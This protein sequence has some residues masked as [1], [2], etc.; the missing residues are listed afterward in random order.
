MIAVCGEALVDLVPDGP[1]SYAALPGG[2]PANCAVALSRLGVPTLLLARLSRDASGRLLRAHLQANGVDLSRAIDADEPSSLAVVS[3]AEDGSA[4]YRFLLEGT[5]DWQWTDDE[6]PALPPAVVAVHSGSL[7]LGRSRPLERFVARCR[8]TSTISIDPNLRAAFLDGATADLDRWLEVADVVKVSTE[9]IA[10]LHPGQSPEQVAHRWAAAGPDLVV[11][12]CADAGAFA[13]VRGQVLRREAV[14]TALVDTVAA[15]DT[16]SAGFLEHLHE[17]RLLGGRL[18][19]LGLDDV[20][21]ALDRGLQAA[22]VTCSRAGADPPW[23]AE[24]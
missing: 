20:V 1:G 11:V 14:P 5:S 17:R 16:F 18:D 19:H 9:D 2:S 13:L 12:T 21:G 10:L 3:V 24:L 6:L 23:A 15:G 7:A 22:A 8:P 4:S